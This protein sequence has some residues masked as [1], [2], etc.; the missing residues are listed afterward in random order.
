MAA[1][2]GC[3]KLIADLCESSINDVPKLNILLLC[4]SAVINKQPDVF[5]AEFLATIKKILTTV[6]DKLTLK[7]CLKCLQRASLMHENNR[8]MIVDAGFVPLLRPYLKCDEAFLLREVC[9]VF[10]YLVLDDDIRVEFGKAHD[11]ARLIAADTL[12]DLTKLQESE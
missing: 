7:H 1:A 5:T 11:H 3:F 4:N 2:N 12:E 6:D 9:C 8:Q 10:R